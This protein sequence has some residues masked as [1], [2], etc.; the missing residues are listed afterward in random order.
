MQTGAFTNAANTYYAAPQQL[1]N[2]GQIIGHNHVVVEEI[3]SLESTQPTNPRV[4]AFFKGL[5]AA[6]AGGQLSADVTKGLPAGTYRMSSITSAANHQSVVM[7]IAQRGSIDDAVYVGLFHPTSRAPFFYIPSSS[8]SVATATMSRLRIPLSAL[9]IPMSTMSTLTVT[10]MV[11]VT[12]RMVET[13]VGVMRGASSNGTEHLDVKVLAV[14]RLL[15]FLADY[16]FVVVR[17]I[18]CCL[19]T[20]PFDPCFPNFTR[21]FAS[22]GLL[23]V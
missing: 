2:A 15:S 18:P 8:P 5:N 10:T 13:T 6:A 17:L 11:V 16:R 19:V 7:P 22:A 23:T 21:P 20:P 3:E 14:A 9:M 4:F 1:N 12:V